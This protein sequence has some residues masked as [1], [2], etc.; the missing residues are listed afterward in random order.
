MLVNGNLDYNLRSNSWWFNL[1]NHTHLGICWSHSA[2]SPRRSSEPGQIQPAAELWLHTALAIQTWLSLTQLNQV[3][4]PYITFLLASGGSGL[5]VV[6]V[7]LETQPISLPL[8][9]GWTDMLSCMANVSQPSRDGNWGKKAVT[10]TSHGHAC[11]SPLQALPPCAC[12]CPEEGL[13]TWKPW[14]NMG[15]EI[16]V[17]VQVADKMEADRRV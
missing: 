1:D 17:L 7:V 11:H 15:S 16:A 13:N 14:R 2:G 5:G 6:N 3:D 9:C 8:W 10:C 4:N 12:D